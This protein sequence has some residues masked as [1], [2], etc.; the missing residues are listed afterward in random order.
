L[1]INSKSKTVI[2]M[3]THG[4]T[5][6]ENNMEINEI[7]KFDYNDSHYEVTKHADGRIELFEASI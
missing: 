4:F 3:W 6:Y 5:L 1:S 7:Y 2:R